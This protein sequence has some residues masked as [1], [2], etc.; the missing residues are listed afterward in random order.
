MRGWD[1][2]EALLRD[3]RNERKLLVREVLVILLIAALLVAR[4]LLL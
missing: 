3:R 2:E 4:A 1:F